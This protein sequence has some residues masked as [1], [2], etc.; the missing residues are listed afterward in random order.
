MAPHSLPSVEIPK[1]AILGVQDAPTKPVGE[2]S[3]VREEAN[4]VVAEVA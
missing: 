2:A 1:K 4:L 3:E